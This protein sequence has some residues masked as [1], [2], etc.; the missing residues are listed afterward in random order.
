MFGAFDF[1]SGGVTGSTVRRVPLPSGSVNE[2]EYYTDT[3]DWIG[4]R[5]KLVSGLRHF[6]EKTGVQPHLYITDTVNGSHSPSAEDLDEFARNLYDELFTDEAHLLLVFFEYDG[7]YMDRYVCGTQAKQIIDTEAADI[8]LDYLD[9]YYYEDGLSDEE[10]FAKSFSDA[11]DRIMT[12]TR[13]PWISVIILIAIVILVW[14]LANWWRRIKAQ[15]NLEARKRE[16]LLSKP[17][18]KF[19]ST[20]AVELAKK[21]EGS[22]P[23]IIGSKERKTIEE[24]PKVAEPEKPVVPDLEPDEPSGSMAPE[25]EVDTPPPEDDGPKSDSNEPKVPTEPDKPESGNSDDPE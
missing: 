8:L 4:N 12:V 25:P 24:E 23:A 16:E 7:G 2:T 13:S 9:R 3:L 1:S 18:E 14:L 11:A 21:Y 15:Q 20:E 10:Y 6:Y 22:P 5:T 19:G 17:L